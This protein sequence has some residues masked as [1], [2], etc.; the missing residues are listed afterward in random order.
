MVR[1]VSC[2]GGR[3]ILF[4]CQD[5]LFFDFIIQVEL[6]HSITLLSFQ[7]CTFEKDARCI[8]VSDEL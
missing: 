4:K 3:P 1:Y 5:T 2:R 6:Q 8:G 7:S